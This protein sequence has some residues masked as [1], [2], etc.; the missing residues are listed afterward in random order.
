MD[1]IFEKLDNHSQL[2][3]VRYV[4]NITKNLDLETLLE[5]PNTNNTNNIINN[6]KPCNYM[7]YVDTTELDSETIN[8]VIVLILNTFLHSTIDIQENASNYLAELTD[9]SSIHHELFHIELYKQTNGI[10]LLVN[11]LRSPNLSIKYGSIKIIK[12]LIKKGIGFESNSQ[13]TILSK[14]IYDHGGINYLHEIIMTCE[15]PQIILDCE[16]LFTLIKTFL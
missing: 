11:L 13:F 6:Y 8:I 2:Y 1:T 9:L 3:S 12:N 7:Q 15:Y 14:L 4:Y 16:E 5:L 10:I